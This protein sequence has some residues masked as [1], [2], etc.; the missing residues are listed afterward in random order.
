MLEP[1]Q[2]RE[3]AS[4]QKLAR[5]ISVFANRKDPKTWSA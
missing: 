4:M 5:I 2:K 3:E 1:V